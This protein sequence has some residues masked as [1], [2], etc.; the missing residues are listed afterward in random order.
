MRLPR[1]TL[2]YHV[3]HAEPVGQK[4]LPFVLGVLADLSGE[5]ETPLPPLLDRGFFDI[6]LDNFETILGQIAP[7]LAF[8]AEYEDPPVGKCSHRVPPALSY[9]R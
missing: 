6:D 1:V 2:T 9:P 8:S 3:D 4:E 7:Q 5:R